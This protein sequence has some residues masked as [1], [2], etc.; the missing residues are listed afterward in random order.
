MIACYSILF[1]LFGILSIIIALFDFLF[2]R[3][4]NVFVA[5]V[6]A[7]FFI[8]ASFGILGENGWIQLQGAL[9]VATMTFLIGLLFYLFKWMGAGDVKFLAATSLWTSYVG[10]NFIFLII[11]SLVGGIIA[12][13]CYFFPG[14]IDGMRLKTIEFLKGHFQNNSFFM[15]YVDKPFLFVENESR[16][17]VRI[18]YGIAITSGSMFVILSILIGQGIR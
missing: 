14:Y 7:L 11:T 15:G 12:G 18:P 1:I 17:K 5:A 16:R 8:L 13:I 4:P 2:Y 9:L 6:S 10:M 3:I